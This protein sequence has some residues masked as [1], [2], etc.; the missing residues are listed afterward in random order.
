MAS[1][2]TENTDRAIFSITFV[3]DGRFFAYAASDNVVVAR[4]PRLR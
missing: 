3:A 2:L 4:I 1:E